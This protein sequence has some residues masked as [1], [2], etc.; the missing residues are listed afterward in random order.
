MHFSRS[1]TPQG[2]GGRKWS[3]ADFQGRVPGESA[4]WPIPQNLI[5]VVM[6][7]GQYGSLRRA[8]AQACSKSQI[9]S[10]SNVRFRL[11]MCTTDDKRRGRFVSIHEDDMDRQRC[12]RLDCG[13]EIHG[14]PGRR[15]S[16]SSSLGQAFYAWVRRR[17][18]S[19]GFVRPVLR[20]SCNSLC[21]A[22]SSRR[23]TSTCLFTPAFQDRR[24]RMP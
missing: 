13:W 12:E 23:S 1:R 24:R 2:L 10:P 14:V 11:L 18:W 7:A 17:W 5:P 3:T 8:I 21:G 19:R 16:E 4:S 15:R 20:A 6:R 22:S 9:A